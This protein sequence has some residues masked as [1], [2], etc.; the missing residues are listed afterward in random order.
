M[1]TNIVKIISKEIIKPSSSPTPTRLRTYKLCL[2]DQLSPPM[3]APLL[4]FYAPT[5][6][7][8][9][10][11]IAHLKSSLSETL[12]HY[13]PF[14]GRFKDAL[15]V[16]C[17]D[18]G[19]IYTEAVVDTDMSSVLNQHDA[20]FLVQLLPCNPHDRSDNLVDQE[21]LLV[22][23]NFFSCGGIAI[24]V[25]VR[26]ALADASALASFVTSWATINR[27]G[28]TEH[29][30]DDM[31]GVVF[32]CTSLFPPQ[33]LSSF[34]MGNYMDKDLLLSTIV[35]RKFV[36]DSSKLSSLKEKIGD[37]P[38]RVEALFALIWGAVIAVTQEKDR[39]SST[40]P[41][42]ATSTV[43]L[44]KRLNPSLPNKCI[45]NINQPILAQW[46]RNTEV[47]YK[48]LAGNLRQSIRSIN[49]EHVRN[50][51]EDGEYLK[52]IKS[53]AE[54]KMV[55]DVFSFSSWCKFPFYEADFGWGK[56][57]WISTHMGLN[58]LAV[59][60]DAKDGEGIEAWVS[61][62]TEDMLKFQQNHGILQYASFQP[63]KI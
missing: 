43:N 14:A 40:K 22:R 38:T 24:G 6:N 31:A 15:S 36:F 3:Y 27:G 7:A 26:H 12:T 41:H 51:H 63:Y 29:E 25:C 2:L 45:G 62:T 56:P 32:D 44:R 8:K 60:I 57:A 61:L 46:P 1:A 30:N 33:D 4:L 17:N 54:M 9:Q 49:D 55:T 11:N 19:V 5:S 39:S 42:L 50:V 53:A 20:G 28:G 35:T 58:N 48:G 18:H 23:V 16:D 10:S 21:M 47:E 37:H 52:F 34:F 59:F 13:F